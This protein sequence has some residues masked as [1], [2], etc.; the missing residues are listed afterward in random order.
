MDSAVAA[1]RDSSISTQVMLG[2][3]AWEK[4]AAKVFHTPA[5]L[6]NAASWLPGRRRKSLT[7]RYPPCLGERLKPEGTPC[8]ACLPDGFHVVPGVPAGTVSS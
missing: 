4:A 2:T 6:S 7:A 5:W 1:A 3:G 8:A